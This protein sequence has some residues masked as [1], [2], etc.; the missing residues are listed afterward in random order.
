MVVDDGC[1]NHYKCFM[2]MNSCLFIVEY[3]GLKL[4]KSIYE[5]IEKC[6]NR[7]YRVCMSFEF[8]GFDTVVFAFFLIFFIDSRLQYE[9][10]EI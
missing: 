5:R 7:T 10:F 3:Q 6:R 1:S 4:S 2:I 8:S 9:N